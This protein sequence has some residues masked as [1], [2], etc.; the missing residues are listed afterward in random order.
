MSRSGKN[1][2][3]LAKHEFHVGFQNGQQR[4]QEK[5]DDFWSLTAILTAV[6]S[7]YGQRDHFIGSGYI[8]MYLKQCVLLFHT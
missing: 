1:A 5:A 6:K 3:V 4:Q 2:N 8:L 7:G